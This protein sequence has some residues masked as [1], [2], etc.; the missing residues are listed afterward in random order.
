MNQKG[1]VIISFHA[2]NIYICRET[3][4]WEGHKGELEDIERPVVVQ[5]KSGKCEM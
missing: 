4:A 5:V 1:S 2:R 3:G